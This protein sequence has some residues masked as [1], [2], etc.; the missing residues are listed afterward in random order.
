VDWFKKISELA[1]LVLIL[2]SEVV[3]LIYCEVLVVLVERKGILELDTTLNHKI[4]T[5]LSDA[6]VSNYS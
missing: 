2:V 3:V 1:K 5:I 4:S 6:A